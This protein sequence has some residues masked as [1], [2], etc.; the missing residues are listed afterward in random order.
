MKQSVE[1][2]DFTRSWTYDMY[3]LAVTVTSRVTVENKWNYTSIPQ[4]QNVLMECTQT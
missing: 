2:D 3:E 1:K 4:A